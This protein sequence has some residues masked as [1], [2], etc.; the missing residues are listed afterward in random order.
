M[1]ASHSDGV[2]RQR[3]V[4]RQPQQLRCA[5]TCHYSCIDDEL[6]GLLARKLLLESAGYRV[7]QARSGPEGIHAF[8][9]GKIDA[10]ILD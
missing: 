9:R 2:S 3:L 7:V 6:T 4:T 8:Q 10:V 5:G 1:P